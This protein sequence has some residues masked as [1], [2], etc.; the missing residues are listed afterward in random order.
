MTPGSKKIFLVKLLFSERIIQIFETKW[1]F[2]STFYQNGFLGCKPQK[3]KGVLMV[4]AFLPIIYIFLNL[5][6]NKKAVLLLLLPPPPPPHVISNLQTL[7]LI[8]SRKNAAFIVPPRGQKS[9]V[10]MSPV[11]RAACAA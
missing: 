5:L 2:H 3:T 10:F 8:S 11:F 7:Q 6:F 1:F 9:G 4:Y